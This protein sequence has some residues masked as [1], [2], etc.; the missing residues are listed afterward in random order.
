MGTNPVVEASTGPNGA[1][2]LIIDRLTFIARVD[3]IALNLTVSQ[4]ELLDY[5]LQRNDR[6][7]G[8]EDIARDVFKATA[9]NAALLVRV[10]I[11][12]LR[13]ALGRNGSL[14][15]T[16]RGRGYRVTGTHKAS[17]PGSSK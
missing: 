17:V 3:G 13:R 9:G 12:H 11:H 6:V 15:A 10:H 16:V 5:L 2:L 14:V 1:A 7:V 4:F 8:C